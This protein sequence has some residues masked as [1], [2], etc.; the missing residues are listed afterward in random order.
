MR[1][2]RV[3]SPASISNLGP[4]FDVLGLALAEPG[5]IVE[6]ELSHEPGVQIVDVTGDGGL[7]S[8]SPDENVAGV[9][10]SAAL[11]LIEQR[12]AGRDAP[13]GGPRG[14][15][16]WLQKAMPLGSG[17]GSSGASSVAGA[18]AVDALFD[19]S[20]SLHDLLHCALEGERVASGAAHADNVAP[21]LFG[22]I[23]LIRSYEP[24]DVV[25]LPVPGD[26]WVSVVHPH[27]SIRTAEARALVKERRFTIDQA[28][29]NL[30][31]LGGLISGFHSGNL[32][33][34][35]RSIQDALVE[36]A[37][38]H[39]IPG[40]HDV[41]KSALEAG[42]LGCSIAGSGPSM[43]AFCDSSTAADAVALAMQRTFEHVARLESDRYVGRA[44]APGAR[45]IE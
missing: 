6:V 12:A 40:F 1:R 26:L 43:F 3:F 44:G 42:A 19:A 37:R 10:A 41:K 32:S 24:L 7:L 38:A 15:R 29:V 31:N 21:T 39:L 23:V 36:P 20:L 33:L 2:I 25:R 34:V 45:T 17:L 13:S 8:R 14:V 16:L 30:G 35:G 28:V 9:S 5:D 11:K 4:G 27:C 22:G 18:V